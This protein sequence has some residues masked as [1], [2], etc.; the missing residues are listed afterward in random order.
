MLI[1]V[2]SKKLIVITIRI[3]LQKLA[4]TDPMTERAYKQN[5]YQYTLKL[6]TIMTKKHSDVICL[7][8]I[9]NDDKL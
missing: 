2:T 8:F 4:S 3:L 1:I 7:L 9:V 6:K 5:R